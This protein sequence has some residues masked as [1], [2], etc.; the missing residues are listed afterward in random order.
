LISEIYEQFL[1]EKD[2]KN[3][4]A[5]KGAYYTPRPLAEF[6]LNKVLPYPT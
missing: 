5:K 1:E 6:I 4:K 3:D 2:G